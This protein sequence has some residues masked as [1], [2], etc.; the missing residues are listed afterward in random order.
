MG[1][2]GRLVVSRKKKVRRKAAK[3]A[4]AKRVSKKKRKARPPSKKKRVGKKTKK[5]GRYE[6]TVSWGF[7]NENKKWIA[8]PANVTNRLVKNGKATYKASNDMR[9]SI[10]TATKTQKNT[11]YGTVRKIKKKTMKTFVTA[12]GKKVPETIMKYIKPFQGALDLDK[13]V[14][15]AKTIAFP[16]KNAKKL[17]KGKKTAYH[18]TAKKNLKPILKKK[19]KINGGKPYP[20]HG[21]LYWRGIYASRTKTIAKRFSEAQNSPLL[22]LEVKKAQTFGNIYVIDDEKNVEVQELILEL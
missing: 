14:V 19:L 16:K 13:V 3:R 20:P 5:T 1:D 18:G 4:V 17:G 21:A 12:K 6:K 2:W 8:Y 7:V 10:S 15:T 11:R 22:K 9:Y